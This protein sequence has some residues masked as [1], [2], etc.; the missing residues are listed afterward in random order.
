MTLITP[1]FK[2]YNYFIIT[3]IKTFCHL[4]VLKIIRYKKL[5]RL[6]SKIWLVLFKYKKPQQ[7]SYCGF[8]TIYLLFIL[9]FL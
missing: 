7:F 5:E 6:K 1:L 3:A 2:K 9:L 8:S 4:N